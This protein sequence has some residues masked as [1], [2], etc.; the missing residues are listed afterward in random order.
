MAWYTPLE[1]VKI[2]VANQYGN[3]VEK[4]LFEERVIWVD[5]HMN[6]LEDLIPSAKPKTKY[7]YIGAVMTLRNVM[8]GKATGHRIGMD[9]SAQGPAIMSALMRDPIGAFNT[10]LIGNQIND[11]YTICTDTMNNL[12]NTDTVYNRD[13]VKG[14]LMP[15]YYGS[16]Q[17]P[18]D[19]FGE[20]TPEHQAFMRAQ[21]AVCPGAAYLMPILR[22]SWNAYA[23]HHYY[24]YPDGF[25]AVVAVTESL[26]KSIEVDELN[27]LTFNYRY[28]EKQGTEKS[29]ANIANVV[30]GTDGYIARELSRR[31]NYDD[32][33]LRRV[34]YLLKLQASKKV[35]QTSPT[36]MEQIW[37]NQ[38]IPS[39]GNAELLQEQDIVKFSS[40]YC[41]ALL[42]IINRCLERPSFPITSIFDEFCAHA[43]YMNWLRLT[44]KEIMAEISDGTLI[45]D[46]LTHLFHKPIRLKKMSDSISE[47]IL[48]GT[49]NI[50]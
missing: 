19:V 28:E 33:Q 46:I 8:A 5:K 47:E 39:I 9:A 20:D 44:Y 7:R 11:V 29:L 17:K 50:G 42:T 10:S 48:N 25:E 3:G 4:M 23:D 1:Y 14:A 35:S 27:H 6:D 24:V 2:D 22:A 15:G 26:E 16:L 31:C 37:L 43:N 32:T 21:E 49:Y 18:K 13:E 12:L 30:Q 41:K 34:A 38:G 45:D 36:R 40:K